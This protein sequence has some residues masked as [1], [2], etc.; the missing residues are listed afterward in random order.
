MN[1]R[2]TGEPLRVGA[3]S[4]DIT[5]AA[6]IRMQG[7]KLRHAEGITDRLSVS[8]LAVGR[9]APE[10]LM[11]VSI[12]SGWTAGLPLESARD[13]QRHSTCRSLP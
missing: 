11:L 8:A 13:C 4:I 6:N 2:H 12:A 7:Y 9:A 1:A 10:W 5:P 3:A